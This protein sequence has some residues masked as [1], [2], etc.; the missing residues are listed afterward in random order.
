MAPP[1]KVAPW[2]FQRQALGTGVA[3]GRSGDRE[4]KPVETSAAEKQ[5]VQTQDESSLQLG[6]PT[7]VLC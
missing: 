1:G 6:N 3:R 7:I 2:T 5:K 4:A